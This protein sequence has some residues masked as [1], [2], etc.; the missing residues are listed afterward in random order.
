LKSFLEGYAALARL[1]VPRPRRVEWSPFLRQIAELYPN[2]SLELAPEEPGWFD[3]AQVE[4]VV[5]N[6]IKNAQEAGSDPAAIELGIRV[7]RDGTAEIEVRDRGPGF[8]TEALKNA[9]LPLYTTKERGSGMGLSLS[10]EI[11]EAHGGSL[12]LMNRPGGGAII[13]VTLPGRPS[14]ASPSMTHSRLTLVRSQPGV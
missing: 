14:P 3:S 11:V 13:R 10:Q 2:I 12:A 8:G 7:A 1:P 9:L 4:Q 5:I 6:L